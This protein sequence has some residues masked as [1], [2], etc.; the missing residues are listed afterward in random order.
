MRL[1]VT[2]FVRRVG[3]ALIVVGV[4]VS[5]L[6]VAHAES[7]ARNRPRLAAR[8][9][10][11]TQVAFIGD[12]ITNLSGPTFRRVLVAQGY[13]EPFVSGINGIRADQRVTE[14]PALLAPVHPDVLVIELGTNDVGQF[15]QDHPGADAATRDAHARTVAANVAA[16][17]GSTPC[18]VIVNVSANTMSPVANDIARAENRALADWVIHE[19]RAHLADWDHVVA[20]EFARGEPDGSMT[21]DTV[22]PTAHGA[23]RLADLVAH[24][25]DTGCQVHA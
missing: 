18:V 21:S 4:L 13:P 6:A 1:F 11:E 16:L 22:H 15:A 12:S 2:R 23:D 5:V 17:A 24:T 7:Q 8:A 19:P 14:A 10:A 9:R 3:A 25:I 20:D